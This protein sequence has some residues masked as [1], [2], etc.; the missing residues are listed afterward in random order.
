MT[1]PKLPKL[2][3]RDVTISCRG[4]LELRGWFPVRLQ[5]GKFRTKDQRTITIGKKG[6]L[7]WVFLRGRECLM[8][9]FKAPGEK[10]SPAQAEFLQWA[11]IQG[12]PAMYADS[13]A[14]LQ[15]KYS[16]WFVR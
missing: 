7:D 11:E 5:S 16:K 13:L 1:T 10:P 6:L 15:A 9:E 2:K 8:V 14:M 12:I 3:E 4:W